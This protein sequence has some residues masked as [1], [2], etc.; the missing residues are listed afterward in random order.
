LSTLL[1][2][3]IE[4]HYNRQELACQILDHLEQAHGVNLLMRTQRGATLLH[5]CILAERDIIGAFLLKKTIEKDRADYL[6]VPYQYEE[7]LLSPL[8][9]VQVQL[10]AY[11]YIDLNSNRGMFDSRNSKRALLNLEKNINYY[12]KDFNKLRK[13]YKRQHSSWFCFKE[14]TLYPLK[15]NF[16]EF[17]SSDNGYK[18]L[19]ENKNSNNAH[20]TY[21]AEELQHKKLK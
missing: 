3:P 15:K 10:E 21:S 5:E 8:K 20:V 16:I 17:F 4:K 7:E 6:E 18:L 19:N 2:K 9:N 14:D 11:S 12:R 1:L 13:D